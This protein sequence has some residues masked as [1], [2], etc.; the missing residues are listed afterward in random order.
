MDV[1]PRSLI[2]DLLSTLSRGSMPVRTL[3]RA[4]E[5]F[6][7]SENNLRVALARLVRAGRV[8]R[9][10][11]GHYRLGEAAQAVNRRVTSWRRGD[12]RLRPWCGEWAGV[13]T[14]GLPRGQRAALR[15]SETALRL[16]GFRALEPGLAIRP[17]N[18]AG[19]V[20]ALR[21][22]LAGLGLDPAAPV[23]RLAEL[24]AEREARARALWDGDSLVASH[25]AAREAIEASGARLAELPPERARVE[26]FTLGG[27]ALR[28]LALDPLLPDE[29]VPGDERRTLVAAM[30]RYDALGRDAW[31]GLLASHGVAQLRAPLD[32]RQTDRPWATADERPR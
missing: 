8:E 28:H 23:V 17:D 3:V 14:S 4:A 1:S 20:P 30:T 7:I 12:E 16:A 24:D 10:A 25:R 21:E 27:A 19:G 31:R 32:T 29:L 5:L 22:A 13:I 11:R 18:L 2:L 26:S 9:D 15:R 6:G